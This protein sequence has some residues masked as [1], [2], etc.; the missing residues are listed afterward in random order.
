MTAGNKQ[1]QQTKTKRT[2][3]PRSLS[4]QSSQLKAIEEQLQQKIAHRQPKEDLA[5]LQERL[6]LLL[7]NIGKLNRELKLTCLK[8]GAENQKV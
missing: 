4:E 8:T 1:I 6:N 5:Q 3:T 7:A 2:K